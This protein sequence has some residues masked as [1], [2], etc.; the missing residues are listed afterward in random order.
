[1]SDKLNNLDE[2]KS[3]LN[4]KR[5]LFNVIVYIIL[6]TSLVLAFIYSV[7]LTREN[8]IDYLL[9]ICFITMSYSL[10]VFL[11]DLIRTNNDIAGLKYIMN[12]LEIDEKYDTDVSIMMNN[13]K[14]TCDLS[15]NYPDKDNVNNRFSDIRSKT[16]KIINGDIETRSNNIKEKLDKEFY[17]RCDGLENN[18]NLFKVKG[19]CLGNDNDSMKI[20]SDLIKDAKDNDEAYDKC[21]YATTKIIDIIVIF[22][23]V[24]LIVIA[25]GFKLMGNKVYSDIL[26][27]LGI[28]VLFSYSLYTY[29]AKPPCDYISFNYPNIAVSPFPKFLLYSVMFSSGIKIISSI[30]KIYILG[31][32]EY[33]WL[34]IY[35]LLFSSTYVIQD[36]SFINILENSYGGFGKFINIMKLDRRED[37]INY[38]MSFVNRNTNKQCIIDGKWDKHNN[39][40]KIKGDLDNCN[41]EF[42]DKY[43][44][45]I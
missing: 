16:S 39:P 7:L 9:F 10:V 22:I 5:T 24:I 15:F 45:Y 30:C 14:N 38:S 8:K 40:P 37:R 2:F 21:S 32:P 42:L 23:V 35:L 27:A 33:S 43:L 6:P 36:Y 20:C 13:N 28:V 25:D 29:V 3:N 34:I 4:N 1:M 18:E 41:S 12:K 44:K 11:I 17:D 31:I 26:N 19:T